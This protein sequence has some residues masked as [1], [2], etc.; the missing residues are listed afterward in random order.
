M[1]VFL[2]FVSQGYLKVTV[3]VLGPG[4]EAPVSSQGIFAGIR[5]ISLSFCVFFF[6]FMG[7]DLRGCN[8]STLFVCSTD[9]VCSG[10]FSRH[11]KFYSLRFL[12][13]I[14]TSMVGVKVVPPMVFSC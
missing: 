14:S 2:W 9:F 10:S 13:K 5:K 11:V 1:M 6:F 8:Y 12:Q 4:D 7:C 3:I